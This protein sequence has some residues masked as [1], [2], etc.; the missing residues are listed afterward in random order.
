MNAFQICILLLISIQIESVISF[1]CGT[2]SLKIEPKLLNEQKN[3]KTSSI[4]KDTEYTPIKMAFDFTTLKKP[5]S[6]SSSTFEKVKSILIDTRSEFSKF[7]QVQ[8]SRI[9]LT[10][11]LD[12]IMEDCG[13]SNIGE[14]YEDFLL[15]NDIIIFPHFDS[16]STGVIASAAPCLLD[17][18]Y[19]PVAGVVYINNKL[20]FDNT[21]INFYMK[22]ILLHE[23]T[24]ILVFHPILFHLLNMNATLNGISYIRSANAVQKARDHFGCGSLKRI[25]LEDQGGRGSVG[26]HW[27]S[28]YMLGDYMISTDYPDTAISDITLGLFEDTGFYQVKDYSGGLFKFGKNKG[29]EFYLNLVLILMGLLI[30]MNFVP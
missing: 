13:L 19:R 3:N 24:H 29:C 5:S 11:Y 28:R 23:I 7:L 10:G 2:D 8:H 16:L 20:N 1:K 6:M 26:S 27:E 14:G 17:D 15:E 22:N 25:P 18:N 30:L 4:L 21:N 12:K 9:D